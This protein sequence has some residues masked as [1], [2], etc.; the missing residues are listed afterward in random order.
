MVDVDV[1]LPVF[2][3]ERTIRSAVTSVLQ[4]SYP[5]LRLIA[6]EDGSTD[7]TGETLA[8]LAKAS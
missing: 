2:N 1:L 7:R 4:Q 5:R 8:E 3:G 6:I